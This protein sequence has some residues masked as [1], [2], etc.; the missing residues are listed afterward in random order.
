MSKRGNK[1]EF[2]DIDQMIADVARDYDIEARGI[3]DNKIVDIFTFIKDFL[4]LEPY[5]W[6]KVA[7]KLFYY[8][9]V[10]NEDIEFDK[11]I[12]DTNRFDLYLF[13]DN[14]APYVQ[15]GTRLSKSRRD[16]LQDYYLEHFNIDILN[17]ISG[18]D[19]E[20]RTKM[21]IDIIKTK[22]EI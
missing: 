16:K 3:K 20:E 7:L 22:F 18:S 15:D 6:Q 8:G 4:K 14:D 21:A 17:R 2:I 12:E 5:P 19:W 1:S 9:S 13:L 11:W 10:G